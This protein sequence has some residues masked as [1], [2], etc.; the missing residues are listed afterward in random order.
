[1]FHSVSWSEP[2]FRL[3]NNTIVKNK[4]RLIESKHLY[5]VSDGHLF[6]SN[7]LLEEAQLFSYALLELAPK[8]Y[9][10]HQLTLHSLSTVG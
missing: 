9:L 2:S 1:M 3:N 4:V 6:I 7:P 10:G 8:L 5:C